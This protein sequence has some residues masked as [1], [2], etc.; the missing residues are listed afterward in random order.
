MRIRIVRSPGILVTYYAEKQV[1]WWWF[2]RWVKFTPHVLTQEQA[3][4]DALT[5]SNG[6]VVK[7]FELED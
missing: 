6:G 1:G 7:E 3:E 4:K 2:K 5:I